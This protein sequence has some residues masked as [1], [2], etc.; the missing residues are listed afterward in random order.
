MAMAFEASTNNIPPKLKV[1]FK[2][3]PYEI[4]E[5]LYETVYKGK[6]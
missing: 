2:C 6:T 3:P 5:I 4:F 1:K